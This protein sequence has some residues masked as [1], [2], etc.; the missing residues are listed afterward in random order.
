MSTHSADLPIG[1]IAIIGMTGRFPGA[2]NV[3]EFWRNVRDGVESISQFEPTDLEIPNARSITADPAYVAARSI[4]EGVELFDA[5]FFGIF[6]KEAELMDPQHRIFLECCWETLEDAGYDPQNYPGAIGVF[7]GCSANTYFLEFLAQHPGFSASYT[8][9]YQVGNYPTMLG[10]NHDF[11]STRVSY[12]LNLRGPSFTLQAGCSTSLLAVCQ[13]CE[14][15]LHYQSDMVLAGGVSITFPQKRGYHYQEG[16]MVSPDGHCRTFDAKSQGTVFG[17]GSGVVLLKRLEDAVADKDHIYAV[18]RGCAVNNDGSTKVGFTAPSVEG[19]AHVVATALAT[20]G[21]DPNSIGYIE[22]HGTGTPLGDPIEVAALTRAYRARTSARNFCALGAVKRNVGHL[23]VAA[24][25]TGLINA[26]NVVRHRQLPPSIYF[27]RPNPS[28]DLESSPFYVNRQLTD[29]MADGPRRAAVSAFGVGGTNAHLILEEAP[30]ADSGPNDKPAHLLL[31][32]ARSESA[33]EVATQNLARHLKEHMVNLAEVAYTLQTGR[34]AFAHRRMLVCRDAAE[35]VQI[36]ESGERT[37]LI[38]RTPASEPAVA[39]LF[40]GQGAQ[41]V[42][43]GSELYRREPAFRKV[44]DRCSEILAPLL[45]F[46]LRAALYPGQVHAEPSGHRF[47]D[48]LVAQPAIFVVEYALAQLW[49]DWG[50]RPQAMIGHSIG[51]FVAATLAGVF[52]LEDALALVAAR[53]RLMQDLPGGSMLAVRLS[54]QDL[55]PLL[56]DLDV[57]AI[58]SPKLTVVAGPDDAIA[59][60]EETLRQKNVVSRRLTTSH[61]FHSRMMESIT[62]PFLERVNQV[63]LHAPQIPYV[64]GVTGRWITAEEATDPV[65]WVKHFRDAV[66]FSEG[67]RELRQTPEWILLEVGPGNTL[68]TL[69]H[70]HP[71]RSAVQPILS[72]L[73]DPS[74]ESSDYL[75]VLNALGSMWLSGIQPVWNAVYGEPRP[76]LLFTTHLSFRTSTVLVRCYESRNSGSPSS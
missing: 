6:P 67:I 57:A 9:A 60:L 39:F 38:T 1:A 11:L 26:V 8:R 27:E 20:A 43:M 22:T 4:L 42:D 5:G 50:I 52:E 72:S 10:A 36:L 59:R 41:H 40:P 56:D 31:L 21:I 58:N 54:E 14:N 69:A 62:G 75:S 13:A 3:G 51:E 34:R 74:S 66:H 25:V 18:I 70:Q 37:R 44:V 19:Q 12:K 28:L 23:D 29:W 32:S 63:R 49:M 71:A 7:A 2:R 55:R 61:A 48:T 53:A 65:Y 46:D 73:A 76:T 30:G 47:N 33:L 68:S 64:S 35:A 45:G 24:G 15:L 17:S 16:G